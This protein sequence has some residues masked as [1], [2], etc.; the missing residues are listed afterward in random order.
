MKKYCKDIDIRDR[1]LIKRSVLE[2]LKDKI[3]RADVLRMF[4][5]YSGISFKMLKNIAKEKNYKLFDGI[6]E[7]IIE[8]IQTEITFEKFVFKPIW[9]TTRIEN[10]KVRRIG[11]QDIKQQLYDYIAVEGLSEVL[12]KKIGYHQFAAIKDKGQVKGAR[13]VKKWIRNKNMRYAWKGDAEHYYENIDTNILKKLLNRYVKNHLLLKLVFTLIDSFENGLS[14]GSYL[15]QYL[16]NFYMSFGY[17]FASEQLFKKRNTKLGISK[18]VRLIS[19]VL[20]YMDDILFIGT[21]L[22]NIKMAVKHFRKW[23]RENLKIKLKELDEWIDLQSGYIDMMGFCISRKKMIVRNRIFRRYR[24]DINKVRRTGIITLK[25]AR[26]IISRDGWLK[27]ADCN[28]WKKKNKADK[29]VGACKEMISNGEN[30]I[31]LSATRSF[32]SC[33]A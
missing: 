10:N 26:R 4:S 20:I 23:M 1:D 33:V 6:I 30:V 24:K 31:Y 28:Y 2:C 25:Q 13:V 5:E 3:G 7:T 11:I 27:N 17:H 29:V 19:H 18:K 9:Y 16:A 15:S 14:I 22:K 32:N 12:K 8:G 21:N